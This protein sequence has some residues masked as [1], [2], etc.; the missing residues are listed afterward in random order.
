MKKMIKFGVLTTIFLSVSIITLSPLIC[1]RHL[2]T[3]IDMGFHL[4][5]AYDLAQ[6]LKNGNLFPFVTTYAFNHLGTQVN[7]AYGL[8]PVKFCKPNKLC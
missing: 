1:S 8:L 2:Y 7:M 5:R 3:G 6:N 4:N